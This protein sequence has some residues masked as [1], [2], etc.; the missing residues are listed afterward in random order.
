MRNKDIIKQYVNTGFSIPLSQLDKLNNS[1]KNSY[2]R[3]RIRISKET[4]LSFDTERLVNL[5]EYERMNDDQKESIFPLIFLTLEDLKKMHPIKLQ[6]FINKWLTFQTKNKD[7]KRYM[8]NIRNMILFIM[9]TYDID[10]LHLII[11]KC[12]ETDEIFL[13]TKDL[14]T[15]IGDKKLIFNGFHYLIDEL[16]SK[17]LMLSTYE[18]YLDSSIVY[19]LSRGLISKS[20]AEDLSKKIFDNF[21]YQK[22]LDIIKIE[23][24]TGIIFLNMAA[25]HHEPFSH[26]IF[27]LGRYKIHKW[28]NIKNLIARSSN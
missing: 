14:F 19:Q 6:D 8:Y 23:I 27:H 17:K 9:F 2:F 12:V 22:K 20:E 21:I 5:P 24:L 10:T 7:I 1:L 28:I 25:M 11:N 18:E 15:R 16:K 26:F 3:K 4:S 13:L